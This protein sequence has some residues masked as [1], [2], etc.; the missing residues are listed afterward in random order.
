MEIYR[1]DIGEI[2]EIVEKIKDIVQARKITGLMFMR[3][4]L[5]MLITTI[6]NRVGEESFQGQHNSCSIAKRVINN[7]WELR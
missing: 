7:L 5:E 1:D 6:L 2:G 4:E 3:R